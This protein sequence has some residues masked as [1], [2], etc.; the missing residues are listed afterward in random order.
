MRKYLTILSV[1]ILILSIVNVAPSKLVFEDNLKRNPIDIEYR[2]F[3]FIYLGLMIATAVLTGIHF[4]IISLKSDT[5]QVKWKG[6]FLLCAFLLFAT[7][8]I[9]DGLLYLS[10]LFLFIFRVIL[11]ISATLFYIGFIMPKWMK[12]IIKI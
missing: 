10:L 9:A 3:V 11:L 7:G 5:I 4:S 8:A 1:C 2:G 12:K 6:R